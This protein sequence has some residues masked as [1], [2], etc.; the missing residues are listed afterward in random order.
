LRVFINTQ[1]FDKMAI[2][3]ILKYT[4]REYEYN[5]EH[6]TFLVKGLQLNEVREKVNEVAGAI[7]AGITGLIGYTGATGSVGPTGDTGPTG[8]V[9]YTGS[10][11][12]QGPTGPTGSSGG[13]Q[14]PTG[15]TGPTGPIGITGPTGADSTVTGPTGIQGPTGSTGSVGATGATGTE[16]TFQY[17][18][19]E[20][21]NVVNLTGDTGAPGNSKYY[22]TDV[23]GTKGWQDT[24]KQYI[25]FA[26]GTTGGRIGIRDGEVVRDKT[27]NSTGFAGVEGVDW[28]NIDAH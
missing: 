8:P 7:N 9:I 23:S 24:I 16:Y 6:D 26:T 17:S 2:E 20:V 4:N 5:D 21:G 10:T 14:G 25:L 11:G 19:Y 18:V 15:P 22:G 27:L 12:A 1:H 3:Y 13:P 28:Y